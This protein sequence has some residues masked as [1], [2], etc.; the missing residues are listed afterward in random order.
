MRYFDT[1]A[2]YNDNIY[3]NDID[4]VLDECKASNVKYIINASYDIISSKKSIELSQKYDY[5]YALIGIHPSEV[6]NCKVDELYDIYNSSDKSKIVG[7]GEAGYDFAYVKDNKEEQRKLFIEQIEMA[8][9]L[10]LPL[11]VHSRDAS[12][13]TYQTIK[14]EKSPENKLLFHCFQPSDDLVRLVLEK[15]YTVAFGGNITYP[16]N[17]SF[18]K[19]I[20]EIPIENIVLETDC[21]Y[22]SPIPH[23][24][25][26]NTSANLNIICEK[27]AEYKELDVEIVSDI[28]FKN[29]VEFF[30]IKD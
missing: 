1:H 30:N 21:P 22:L 12:E 28:V 29:A 2:H 20:K 8:N 9:N 11:I 7:I 10:K 27:L 15:N 16:R 13:S 26:R 18:K 25:K 3:E 14:C 23:R 24:G 6:G 4:A 19:Y 5:I 17:E